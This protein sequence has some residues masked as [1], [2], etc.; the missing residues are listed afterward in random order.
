MG[1]KLLV[2]R[3][4]VERGV[5]FVQVECGSWDHHGDLAR[6]LKAKAGEIDGTCG[7]R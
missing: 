6:A 4:L 1:S 2:A 3:R 5:R 7:P